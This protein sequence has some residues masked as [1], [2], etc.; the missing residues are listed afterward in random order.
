MKKDLSIFGLLVALC[1]IT[2]SQNHNFFFATNLTN[3]SN[4]IGLFGIFSIGSGLV[5]IAGGIDL[6]IGSMIALVGVLL[7][8]AL[9]EWHWPWPLA[10]AFVLGVSMFFGWCHGQLV[11]RLKIQ[12]FIVTLCALLIYRGMARYITDD[13]TKGFG[14]MK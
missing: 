3:L 4:I 7:P 2:A 10:V 6:S 9:R 11:T 12:P 1:L 8:M 14:D 5:I 13:T